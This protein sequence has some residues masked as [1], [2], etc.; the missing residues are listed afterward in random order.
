[1]CCFHFPVHGVKLV[2][3]QYLGGVGNNRTKRERRTKKVNSPAQYVCIKILGSCGYCWPVIVIS[4]V[5]FSVF[6]MLLVIRKNHSVAGKYS[7]AD[8]SV[9]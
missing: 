7:L 1:M 3:V 2:Y 5:L 4:F 9:L 8:F 6:L